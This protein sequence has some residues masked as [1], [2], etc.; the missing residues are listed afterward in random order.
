MTTHYRFP[1]TPEQ[2]FSAKSRSR[3]GTRHGFYRNGMKRMLDILLVLAGSIFVVPLVMVL[4][5]LVAIDGGRPFYR[6]DRVGMNGRIY[7][8]WKLRSMVVDADEKLADYLAADPAARM[9]WDHSQKLR[10]DP[11][12]TRIGHVLRRTSLDELPQLWNV[13]RG[14][15]SLVGPRPMMPSQRSMYPG[16]AYYALRPGITGLWQV[17]ARNESGFAARASF[18]AEYDRTLSFATDCRL[19][20]AT[21]HAVTRGTGC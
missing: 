20:A 1:D 19:L 18:D 10:C 8:M 3:F 21:L 14:D 9:E 4:S 2:A 11:R 13:L 7:R 16:D 17:S 12:I 15:M 5:I 6:Q